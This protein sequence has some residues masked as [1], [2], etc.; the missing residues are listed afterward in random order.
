MGRGKVAMKQRKSRRR[1]N[2]RLAVAVDG[3]A[4][5]VENMPDASAAWLADFINAR[6]KLLGD[7]PQAVVIA[8]RQK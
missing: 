8:P 2:A 1:T 3:K 4:I 5:R 6:S 7:G